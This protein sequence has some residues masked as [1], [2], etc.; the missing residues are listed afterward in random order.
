MPPFNLCDPSFTDILEWRHDSIPYIAI[1]GELG[2]AVLELIGRFQHDNYFHLD[3][4][5]KAYTCIPNNCS[6]NAAVAYLT[7][8]ERCC[9]NYGVLWLKACG[10]LEKL[11]DMFKETRPEKSTGGVVEYQDIV[12]LHNLYRLKAGCSVNQQYKI[13]ECEHTKNDC[14]VEE[15][16]THI[17]WPALKFRPIEVRT[18]LRKFSPSPIPVYSE[19][20]KLIQPC[21]VP[22]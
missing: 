19:C 4:V 3:T 18:T 1:P 16:E 20:G 7:S 15:N 13:T 11:C 21:M 12:F 6:Q 10:A 17:C 22:H 8:P 5:G 9:I 2:P 14:F